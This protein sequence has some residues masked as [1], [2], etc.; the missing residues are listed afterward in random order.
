MAFDPYYEWLGISLGEQPPNHYRL[1]GVNLFEPS[2]DVISNAADQRM[3]FLQAK[4]HGQN[5]MDVERLLNEV[6]AARVC[7]L[8]PDNK[9][10]YD[11]HLRN[12]NTFTPPLPR[13]ISPEQVKQ[14]KQRARPEVVIEAELIPE[15]YEQTRQRMAQPAQPQRRDTMFCQHCGKEISKRAAICMGCGVP[16]PNFHQQ[17]PQQPPIRQSEVAGSTVACGYFLA[18]LQP[19]FGVVAAVYMIN[20]KEAGHGVGMLVLSGFSFLFFWLP[21]MVSILGV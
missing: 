7:L 8:N 5:G 13:K 19:A 16:T 11:Q 18:L 3:T 1:L 6:S 14:E 4:R 12:T 17:P 20:K 21:I 9:T 2:G 15:E 10:T